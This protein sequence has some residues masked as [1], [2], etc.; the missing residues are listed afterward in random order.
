MRVCVLTGLP[1]VFLTPISFVRVKLLS[2]IA[3]DDDGVISARAR[4]RERET[5]RQTCIQAERE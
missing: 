1:L 4:E 3:A 2:F 5:D